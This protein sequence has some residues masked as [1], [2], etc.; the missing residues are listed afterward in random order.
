MLVARPTLREV[1]PAEVVAESPG[2]PPPWYVQGFSGFA[3]WLSAVLLVLFSLLA[4]LADH[5][6]LM[7]LF[8]V[9][10]AASASWARRT[11]LARGVF[12]SQFL[13]ASM[14]AGEGLAIA[15]G[16]ELFDDEASV[17]LFGGLVLVAAVFAYPDSLH[18]F[19]ATVVGGAMLGGFVFEF[20]PDV[21]LHALATPLFTLGAA[22]F[23]W[24][25]R[26]AGHPWAELRAPVAYGSL[27]GAFLLVMLAL[28]GPDDQRA[29]AFVTTLGLT[30][31]TAVG[32]VTTVLT[33][34]ELDEDASVQ[35]A[36]VATT[37]ALGALTWST[38]GVMAALATLLLAFH[39]RNPALFALGA[40]FL[41]VFLTWF[42][43]DLALTLWV[44]AGLLL[45][46]GSLLLGA[47]LLLQAP[48][49]EAP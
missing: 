19:G 34:L 21:P 7:L 4:G 1:L 37:L 38:P 48:A 28:W 30:A 9:M 41:A 10:L 20:V 3:A 26:I 15:A 17:L 36:V 33:E 45:G 11:D 8:G 39:R 6:A 14:V 32:L 47:R 49:G 31:V 44:K 42:Y 35:V 25:A 16:G 40:G 24:E 46:S 29:G 2:E 22:L 43:Y 27:V 5:G 18:R 13:L 12:L 23:L